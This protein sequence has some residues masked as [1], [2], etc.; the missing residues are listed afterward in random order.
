MHEYIAVNLVVSP[1]ECYTYLRYIDL[2]TKIVTISHHD[3]N[4]QEMQ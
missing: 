4:Y 3:Y 1:R 2:V